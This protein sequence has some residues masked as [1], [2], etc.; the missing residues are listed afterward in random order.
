MNVTVVSSSPNTDGLT[1]ACAESTLDGLAATGVDTNDVRLCDMNVG[2]CEQCGDGWG[3]C[4]RQHRCQVTDD[5]QDLHQT[6]LDSEAVILIT[7]IYWGDFSESMK[8][9]TD[10][11][12]RCEALREDDSGIFGTWFVGVA[13]AGG[14]GGGVPR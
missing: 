3:T 2:M 11:L 6:V 9:F 13:A 1:A 14:G 4:Q 7:P 12:R 10:R 8:A 5:F